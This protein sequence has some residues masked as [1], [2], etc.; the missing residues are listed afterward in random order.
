MWSLLKLILQVRWDARLKDSTNSIK[1]VYAIQKNS[2]RVALISLLLHIMG[3]SNRICKFSVSASMW[4]DRV[5]RCRQCEKREQLRA[6]WQLLSK[7]VCFSNMKSRIFFCGLKNFL[8]TWMFFFQIK[9]SVYSLT[10]FWANRLHYCPQHETKLLILP[11]NC[12]R[13]WCK[14]TIF[15][16]TK[17][18]TKITHTLIVEL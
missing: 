4:I 8:R 6:L 16:S 17:H 11:R 12:S 7:H 10:Y 9:E 3:S 15:S 14:N 5:I 13:A 2:Q 1:L 18:R